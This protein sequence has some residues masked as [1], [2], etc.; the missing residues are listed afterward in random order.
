MTT[1]IILEKIR[2][3]AQMVL[4]A[5]M[6]ESMDVHAQNRI[7]DEIL[8]DFQGSVYAERKAETVT[9][10]V[11]YKIPD[12]WFQMLKSEVAPKWFLK[13]WPVRMKQMSKQ[14]TETVEWV[15]PHPEIY[16]REKQPFL[17]IPI[18]TYAK[19]NPE[20]QNPS[21]SPQ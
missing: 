19:V 21:Y 6:I 8:L 4:S 7:I 5:P 15:V 14:K 3:R 20:Y 11:T 17:K 2:T 1:E 13:R 12:G 9:V 10:S 18:G 16:P